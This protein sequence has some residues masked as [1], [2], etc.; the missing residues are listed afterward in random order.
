MAFI[1]TGLLLEFAIRVGFDDV[2]SVPGLLEQLFT[3]SDRTGEGGELGAGQREPLS[4]DYFQQRLAAVPRRAGE[5]GM[6]SIWRNTFPTIEEIRQYLSE[7][8]IKIIH[9]FP[10]TMM[11]LPCISIRMDNDN[12]TDYVGTTAGDFEG[13]NGRAHQIIAEFDTT[14][15]VSIATGA[16]SYTAIWYAIIKYSIMRYKQVLEAY[17]MKNLSQAW[18][19]VEPRTEFTEAGNFVYQRD[20]A[21]NCQKTEGF[22]VEVNGFSELEGTVSTIGNDE[23]IPLGVG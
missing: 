13:P 8:N 11:D 2:V 1:N 19:D 20:C 6:Q 21:V 18:G 22:Y 23:Q 4:M 10:M 7:C 3:T 15:T 5:V 9:G 17:G 16:E 14:H 12:D